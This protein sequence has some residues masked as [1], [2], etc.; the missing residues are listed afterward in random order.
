[1]YG[2]CLPP[3]CGGGRGDLLPP[4]AVHGLVNKEAGAAVGAFA[5]R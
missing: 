4:Q 3:A 2:G 5:Q 1:M